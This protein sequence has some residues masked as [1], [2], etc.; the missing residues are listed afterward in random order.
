MPVCDR[1]L[2][3]RKGRYGEFVGCSGYPECKFIRKDEKDE[4][5]PTGQTC[6]QCGKHQLVERKG[7]F[8]TF[9][10]CAG[11]PECNY[12]ANPPR[13]DGKPRAE[14]KVL[15]EPCPVCGKPM[16]ERRGRFGTFKSCSDY[17]R[18]KGPQGAKKTPVTA[19]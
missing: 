4:P 3:R 10:A 6:P 9:L 14:P 5:K 16:V 12:R 2:Q 15:D 8:G 19:V 11:Y 7:R 18:C 17:P 13:K 1:P